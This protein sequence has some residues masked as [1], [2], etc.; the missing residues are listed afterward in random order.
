MEEVVQTLSNPDQTKRVRIVRRENGAFGYEEEYFS[1]DEREMAW[2][3]T[4][5][6]DHSASVIRSRRH[7][8]KFEDGSAG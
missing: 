7:F 8:A 3:P 4:G 1:S 6:N 2:V 5:A